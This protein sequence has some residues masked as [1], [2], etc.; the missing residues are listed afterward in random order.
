M[1]SL[2]IC[3][4]LG[5]ISAVKIPVTVD[6]PENL[7][8]EFKAD[9]MQFMH[10]QQSFLGSSLMDFPNFNIEFPRFDQ[11]PEMKKIQSEMDRKMAEA[12]GDE[13]P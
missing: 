2:A 10:P 3:A 9:P 1:K 8:Q 13:Q 6:V 4:L 7:L 11:N 12:W 5:E